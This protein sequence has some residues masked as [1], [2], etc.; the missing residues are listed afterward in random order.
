MASSVQITGSDL[1]ELQFTYSRGVEWTIENSP[2]NYAEYISTVPPLTE[3]R[4]LICDPKSTYFSDSAS[5]V[6]DIISL[7]NQFNLGSDLCM[8][9]IELCEEPFPQFVSLNALISTMSVNVDHRRYNEYAFRALNDGEGARDKCKVMIDSYMIKTANDSVDRDPN[10][11][12]LFGDNKANIKENKPIAN[13][14][15]HQSKGEP[16]SCKRWLK[17]YFDINTKDIYYNDKNEY[18]GGYD[19]YILVIYKTKGNAEFQ[20]GQIQ[21]ICHDKS[22]MMLSNQFDDKMNRLIKS[23]HKKGIPMQDLQDYIDRVNVADIL[24]TRE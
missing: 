24:N 20:I 7:L 18:N 9:I 1:D 13:I 12:I 22:R 6:N 5:L 21:F 2:N 15:D 3:W 23:F 4:K 14:I 8:S 10:K 19:T 11:W 16:L 17:C